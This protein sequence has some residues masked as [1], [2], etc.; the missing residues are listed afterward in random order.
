MRE[1]ILSA[2]K[3]FVA[4]H[5]AKPPRKGRDRLPPGQTLSAGFPVLDLGIHPAFDPRTWS[6]SVEGEVANPRTWTWPEFSRL[7]QIEQVSDFHC[8]TTWSKFDVSWG[9]VQF[10]TLADIVLPGERARFVVCHCSDDYTTNIPIDDALAPDVI[11]ACK[12]D[13]APLPVEHGGPARLVVPKLYAW[14]SAKFIRKIS[15]VEKDD[16]GF[17]ESRG[18][19]SHGDPWKEERFSQTIV[20]STPN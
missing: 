4:L 17:W 11:L 7:P 19:H 8:V 13:G 5:G 18:Y 16:P 2:K 6:F 3:K 1:K 9:G 10:K 14:K 12:L 15:F 20:F